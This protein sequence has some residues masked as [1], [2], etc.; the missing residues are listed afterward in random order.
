MLTHAAGLAAGLVAEAP[1][2]VRPQCALDRAAGVLGEYQPAQWT[3]AEWF[4][5][6]EKYRCAKRDVL[7]IDG[8]AAAA[9]QWYAQRADRAFLL[10]V[11]LIAG[12]QFAEEHISRIDVE[13]LLQASRIAACPLLDPFHRSLV[14]RELLLV[15]QPAT[16]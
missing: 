4:G 7:W 5:G 15:N 1:E 9:A 2:K 12:R 13:Q 14:E 6:A 8:N 16:D 3:F 11:A 10:A